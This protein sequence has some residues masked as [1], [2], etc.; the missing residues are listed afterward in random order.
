[1]L[2]QRTIVKI[3]LAVLHDNRLLLVRKKGGQSYILPG[4]KAEVGEDDR[5]ALVREIHEELGCTIDP[6]SLIFLGAF[7]DLAADLKDT[8]VIVRLYGA[9]LVGAPAP[10]SEIECLTWFEPDRN[11]AVSLA[12]SI[13]NQ[14]LPFSDQQD[15]WRLLARSQSLHEAQYKIPLAR[16][17]YLG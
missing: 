14:I 4:G 8:V 11:G 5:Q 16:H 9:N 1:M 2:P 15:C 3:G 17:R 13:R 7:S 10:T 6:G 12:P